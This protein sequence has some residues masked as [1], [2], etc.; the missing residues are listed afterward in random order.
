MA[1]PLNPQAQIL[2]L[3]TLVNARIDLVTKHTQEQEATR[4]EALRQKIAQNMAEIEKKKAEIQTVISPADLDLPSDPALEAELKQILANVLATPAADVPPPLAAGAAT[5]PIPQH[6]LQAGARSS[7][8]HGED[9]PT[10]KTDRPNC[11]YGVLPSS[12]GPVITVNI[13]NGKASISVPSTEG[14]STREKVSLAKDFVET[15][16]LT[17]AYKKDEKGEPVFNMSTHDPEFRMAVSEQL[18]LLGYQCNS[19]DQ[20]RDVAYANSQNPLS[21]LFDSQL[22]QAV[23][24]LMSG[25]KGSTSYGDFRLQAKQ[26]DIAKKVREHNKIPEGMPIDPTTVRQLFL[27]QMLD[28]PTREQ[29]AE[30]FKEAAKPSIFSPSGIKHYAQKGAG[31]L[32]RGDSAKLTRLEAERNEQLQQDGRR[33]VEA[34]A[35]GSLQLQPDD[36]ALPHIARYVKEGVANY[37]FGSSEAGQEAMT[38]ARASAL[39]TGDLTHL[40]T[41]GDIK[42]REVAAEAEAKAQAKPAAGPES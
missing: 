22:G 23:T 32:T 18:N 13:I 36:P 38:K 4:K 39:A 19:S 30:R 9:T 26:R 5:A 1:T 29:I 14:L 41:I 27:K 25:G 12:G 20:A 8:M 31:M 3:R 15:A 11:S 10:V 42:A 34:R 40:S 24:N 2:E 17:G 35:A 6:P 37:N 33:R 21:V 28:K 7:A 16:L